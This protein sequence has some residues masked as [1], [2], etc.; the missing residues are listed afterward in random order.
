MEN[1]G[2]DTTSPH[3]D[4]LPLDLQNKEERGG[5]YGRLAA[6]PSTIIRGG[7]KVAFFGGRPWGQTEGKKGRQEGASSSSFSAYSSSRD[8]DR[9]ELQMITPVLTYPYEEESAKDTPSLL[10]PAFSSKRRHRAEYYDDVDYEEEGNDKKDEETEEEGADVDEYEYETDIE[11][12]EG[13]DGG[14]GGEDNADGTDEEEEEEE[15]EEV[16]EAAGADQDTFDIDETM[17]DNFWKDVRL[18]IVDD[19]DQIGADEDEDED[20]RSGASFDIPP[21]L[22]PTEKEE[23]RARVRQ[24]A[25]GTESGAGGDEA[26][27][28]VLSSAPPMYTIQPTYEDAKNP[29]PTTVEPTMILATNAPSYFPDPDIRLHILNFDTT[30]GSDSTSSSAG[31]VS[32]SVWNDAAADDDDHPSWFDGARRSNELKSN[33]PKSDAD[34]VF[35]FDITLV[36][37]LSVDRVWLLEGLASRWGGEVVAAI[38]VQSLEDL[39]VVAMVQE[40]LRGYPLKIL[41]A[42]LKPR[43][44]DLPKRLANETEG[45]TEYPINL[46]R[47]LA[48]EGAKTSHYLL[49]DVDMWPSV[50]LRTKLRESLQSCPSCSGPRSTIVVPAFSMRGKWDREEEILTMTMEQAKLETNNIPYDSIDLKRCVRRDQFKFTSM[51]LPDFRCGIFGG[52]QNHYGHSSTKIFH[53]W[54]QEGLRQLDCI[55]SD[56]YEPY[57]VLPRREFEHLS[58]DGA[59]TGYGANKIELIMRLRLMG[60]TFYVV[61]K[62]FVFHHPHPYSPSKVKWWGTGQDNSYRM[63]RRLIFRDIIKESKAKLSEQGLLAG[64]G[65]EDEKGGKGTPCCYRHFRHSHTRK[66]QCLPYYKK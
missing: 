32:T 7:G 5:T 52:E 15:E 16:E 25:D 62:G 14:G 57:V 59:F 18:H 29:D 26:S 30:Y 21:P 1:D 8:E 17:D 63:R 49:L 65:G 34:V 50:D 19:K 66:R 4:A 33:D 64:E 61:D 46:M 41:A 9:E 60:F 39:Q 54:R 44:Q 56:R 36:T 23:T 24:A 58:Y 31:T 38:F 28:T 47:N 13:H 42:S 12:Q 40:V 10:N 27:T 11:E 22:S 48:I 2:D 51:P 43:A 35:Q 45:L 55:E 6:T 37:Q 20:D 3:D 53:W